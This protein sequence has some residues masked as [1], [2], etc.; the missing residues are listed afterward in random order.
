MNDPKI[1][2]M[3]EFASASG[4]SRPT[5]SK[6][7]NDPQS[8]RESTRQRIEAALEQYDYRPNIYAIN[9]NRRLTKNIGIV[10]PY[11]ADPF[12]AEIARNI[13]NLIIASGFRTILLSSH[14]DPK[15]ELDNL[16]LLRS[17]KPAGVLLAPLG[18][19]SDPAAVKA[20]CDD[21]P[22]V[23]FD[24]NISDLGE[25]FIGHNNVQATE[26][27]C[28]YLCRTGEPPVF[29]EMRTPP[30]PNA[31]RR[32]KA[33]CEVME[34]LGFPTQLIQVDGEGWNFEEIGYVEGK[35]VISQRLLTTNT[36]LCSND[37]LA[38]GFL[39]AAFET[40]QR[41]GRG[42]DC[43]LR[44][45]G[46]DNHPY[47]RFT[48][49]PLTTISH[50]YVLIAEKSVETLLSFIESGERAQSRETTLF[51]GKLMMRSSA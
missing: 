16:D 20:F 40:G 15:Q 46:H 9:Q 43:A 1:R 34:K 25:A 18:R 51:D 11:L 13:E 32:R 6:Y 4:I 24:C 28:E 49:P 48:C 31:Y 45:A 7:F 21:V 23:L 26:Q 42:E 8:V 44:V 33:Y 5:V 2:N 17:I 12:F 35:R 50:D 3:E 39:T 41:V 38:I 36:V 14:G 47:S 19:A 22:T 30:N 10:V 29:F 27:I 37:R